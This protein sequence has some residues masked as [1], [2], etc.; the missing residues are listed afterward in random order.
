MSARYLH[1]AWLAVAAIACGL[2]GGPSPI[3]RIVTTPP[4]V[5]IVGVTRMTFTTESSGLPAGPL[6]Y[7]W[8][9]GD[10]S[11]ARGAVVS[12]LFTQ[13]G[14]FDVIVKASGDGKDIQTSVRMP[15]RSLNGIWQRLDGLGPAGFPFTFRLVQR[16]N[17]L[18]SD[19]N[20]PSLCPVF[21]EEFRPPF[22][23]IRGTVE[24]PRIIRWT[25]VCVG[26][27]PFLGS[28]SPDL[29]SISGG[30][31]PGIYTTYGRTGS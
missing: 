7:S 24:D 6:D 19:I 20:S 11:T 25:L 27:R 3:I 4:G 21:R 28:V 30:Y 16:G 10:G 18:S 31:L 9:F 14:A 8:T 2:A 23:T 26:E 1:V 15:V 22:G 29:D 13:E 17:V 5:P 12:H